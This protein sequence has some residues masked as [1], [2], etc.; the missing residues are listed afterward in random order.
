MRLDSPFLPLSSSSSDLAALPPSVEPLRTRLSEI[1]GVSAKQTMVTRG[2][3]HGFELAL[4]RARN[5]GYEGV[6]AEADPYIEDLLAI[7]N[8][9]LRSVPKSG[10]I[11]KTTG[12]Y[13]IENPQS[14]NGKPW[15]L[16]EARSLAV[17]IFPATLVIDESYLD[18]CE[19]PGLKDL[20][21]SETNVII[22][23]SLS[24]LYGLAGARVGALLTNPK[25]LQGLIRVCEPHPLP[26]PS[27]QAAM[28]ALAPS[29]TLAVQ[30]RIRNLNTQRDRLKEALPLID[31]IEGFEIDQGPTFLIRP[32][33]ATATQSNLK[34]YSVP[35]QTHTEGLILAIG[36]Q[37]HTDRLLSALGL[38][39][40]PELAPRQA[41]T[42][43]DTKETKI[44]L[45]HQS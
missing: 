34:R 21:D 7:Y 40:V 2:A 25:T 42:T 23:K 31:T 45:P 26:T 36:T 9:E 28:H 20:L 1:Y 38:G 22:L 13:R 19:S 32:K 12:I 27:L 18:I 8:L 15:D 11:A 37:D 10:T 33:N 39:I 4:R 17:A 29:R 30:E 44:S 43:R 16:I 6:I 5:A 24:Y 14:R 35:S 41:E 3:S